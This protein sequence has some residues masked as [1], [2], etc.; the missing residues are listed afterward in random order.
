MECVRIGVIGA[1]VIGATHSVVLRQISRALPGR[2]H[3]VAL[4]DP[5]GA[6]QALFR[7]FYG[8]EQCYADGRTLL[9]D[10]AVNTVFV[11]TP[12]RYHAEFVHAAARKGLHVFCEKPLAMDHAEGAA[13]VAAIEAAGV[14]SQI[15]L[16][17]R[18]SAVYTVMRELLQQPQ[19]G[20]PLAVVFRDD[21]CFPIRGVHE[22]AWRADRTL[23]AGGTLIEHGV[24]DLDLLTW[25]F[26]PV[27]R[28]HAW[29]HNRAGHAGIE[30]YMAV[31][32]EFVGGVRAQLINVWHNMVQR[33]SNRR[34][35]IFCDN[36]FIASDADMSG[37]ITYQFGDG[38]EQIMRADEV[39]RRFAAM[40]AQ[41]PDG[42]RDYFGVSYLVQDLAFVEAL[43]A[44]RAPAPSIHIGLEAQ[45]LAA[46]TYHAAR[47]RTEVD[48][49]KFTAQ[50]AAC[51]A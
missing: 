31:E 6:R 44:D 17:L 32:M 13:M 35:E 42:L 8:Y 50:D 46:A 16:V 39:L 37:D 45:R 3:L 11:C 12:T 26:G 33:P 19:A 41:V 10:A 27:R 22:S 15:G 38:S 34:L 2:V 25:F 40:H 30:D 20:R 43:L 29:E 28:M 18:F 7:E 47:S 49:E 51:R 9:A 23:T 24:H 14:A 4:A 1:G 5:L 48:V 36:A 21:Q